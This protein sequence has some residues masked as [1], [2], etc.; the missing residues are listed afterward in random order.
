MQSLSGR[1]TIFKC[2]PSTWA[3]CS[4]NIPHSKSQQV[5]FVET[6]MVIPKFTA[7]DSENGQ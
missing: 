3:L 5:F 6:K 2:Q 7:F 4:L 1:L